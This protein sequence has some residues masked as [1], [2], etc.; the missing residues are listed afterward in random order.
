MSVNTNQ[1]NANA[2]TSFFAPASG[3]GGG[4]GSNFP[5]GATFGTPGTGGATIGVSSINQT[6]NTTLSNVGWW[7][8]DIN[9]NPAS[10]A[11][12]GITGIR[13]TYNP[14]DAGQTALYLGAGYTDGAFIWAIWDG[15]IWMPLQIRGA[16]INMVSGQGDESFMAMDGDNN[17][18][19]VGSNMDFISDTNT[20]KVISDPTKTYNADVT[21]LFSTL[22]SLYPSCFI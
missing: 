8:H 2:T 15:Y 21:A 11:Q 18:I 6:W 22:Q 3:G 5:N 9:L 10:N 1:T 7:P 4:G 14:D 19:T 12:G 20:F 13:I 17:T 16:Q